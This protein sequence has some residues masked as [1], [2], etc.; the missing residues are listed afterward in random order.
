PFF[1]YF[2][3]SLFCGA[4]RWSWQGVLA[5][6]PAVIIAFITIAAS[7]SLTLGGTEF[8]VNRFIVRAGYLFMISVLL[9]YLG[10]HETRLREEIRRLAGWPPTVGSDTAE[11]VRRVIEHAAGIVA[12]DRVAVVWEIDEEPRAFLAVWT[13]RTYEFVQHASSALEPWVAAELA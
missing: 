13:R 3:F 8:E 10:L 9:V 2:I 7:M 4:M 5:T 11:E 6:A 12:A 1:T